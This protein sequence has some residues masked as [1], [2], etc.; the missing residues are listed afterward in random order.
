VLKKITKLQSVG[1]FQSGTPKP[2]NFDRVTLLY[3]EN[4]RGK[5]TLAS[6]LRAC[7]LG[8][9]VKMQAKKTLDTATSQEAELLFELDGKNTPISFTNGQWNARGPQIVVFDAEFVEQNVYSGQEVRPEQRQALLEFVL[10]EKAI[11]LKKQISDL[12][13]KISDEMAKRSDAEKR[14]A[15]YSQQ[16][17]L[18]QFVALPPIADAQQ[19]ID[20]F[21]K[22]IVS[23]TSTATI[24][25]RQAPTTLVA[26]VFDI[27]IFF[28]VLATKL[29]DVERGAEALVREHF[30]KHA[31]PPEIDSLG[32]E[33]WIST[34]QHFAKADD[35][36]F[37]GQKL[38]GL[39][40]IE[41]YKGYFNDAYIGLKEQVVAL[42]QQAATDLAD[43][44]IS[45]L[46]G[47]VATNTARLEAWKDHLDITIPLLSSINLTQS[48]TV[49]RTVA[50]RLAAAKQSHPLDTFGAVTDKSL[51]AEGLSQIHAA[52]AVYNTQIDTANALINDFKKKLS[53]EN[54]QALKT[55]VRSL[56]ISLA[57]QHPEALEAIGDYQA[58]EA[59]RKKCDEEKTQTRDQLDQLMVDTLA[60]YQG[61]INKLLGMFGAGFTIEQMKP[62][63]QGT[64]EPRTEYG[65]R[66]RDR[67]V[68]LGSRKEAGMHFGSTLSEG[69]KRTLA[70]A[71]FLARVTADPALIKHQIL[72]LDDPVC[73]LDR[74]R[75]AQTVEML[76]ELAGKCAQM[77]VLSHD[78]YFVR[79]QRDML[80]K[81]APPIIP[82]IVGISRVADDYSA[83]AV[84]D[85]DDLCASDYYRHHRQLSEYVA[86]AYE[87]NIRDVAKAIRLFL[88]GFYHR[89]FPGLLPTHCTFGAVIGEVTKAP[90]GTP[91]SYL[92][93]SVEEMTKLN[94]YAG[95]FHHDTNPGNADTAPVT[96]GEL[97]PYVQRALALV[98]KG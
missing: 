90:V 79:E 69:D 28:S 6:L 48:I 74:N 10:G 5:S 75:R 56:E 61:Q 33:S 55:Q 91:I 50:M 57:R 96:D 76:T 38:K 45:V 54:V 78:A 22:R 12:T 9:V 97:K 14:I 31:S 40:L 95:R 85:I 32:I 92:Q 26:P 44:R 24:A 73:S 87:G 42:A 63:Y 35:C 88:E 77:I 58:A 52:I 37:C 1:L 65:L 46:I 36:P 67:P 66:L 3:A 2:A 93:S 62:N 34:G 16:T 21:S 72:V 18:S 83:F 41:A 7:A 80:A 68:H 98:Y 53:G 49:A 29:E 71:F 89:R 86:G 84:C 25:V 13:K 81:N 51:I 4:G 19:Q 82:H 94:I 17:P 20:A 27:E 39:A 43:E 11:K 23:A 47:Q 70:F 60:K 30:A 64:G 59:E 15:S 8:D